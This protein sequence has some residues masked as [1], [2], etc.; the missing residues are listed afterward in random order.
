MKRQTGP[1]ASALRSSKRCEEV[2]HVLLR[3]TNEQDLSRQGKLQD[4]N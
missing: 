1:F 4:L 3:Q 2:R